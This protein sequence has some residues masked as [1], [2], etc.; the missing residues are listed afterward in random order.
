MG[1]VVD[2]VALEQGFLSL[3]ST[4]PDPLSIPLLFITHLTQPLQVSTQDI[5][6][7]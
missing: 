7:F 2:E 3:T 6:K 5:I 4:F 1:F